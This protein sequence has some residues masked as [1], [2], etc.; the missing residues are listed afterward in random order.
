MTFITDDDF[1]ALNYVPA[2]RLKR[3][4]QALTA[5]VRDRGEDDRGKKITGFFEGHDWAGFV[6]AG[7]W[8]ADCVV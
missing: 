6:S 1:T 3:M 7:Y 2:H 5:D 4:Y 8:S